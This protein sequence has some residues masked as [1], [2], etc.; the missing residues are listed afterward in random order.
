MQRILLTLALLLLPAS[1]LAQTGTLIQ[2]GNLSFF[3]DSSGRIGTLIDP[4][5]GS[6]KFYSDSTGTFGTII[7]GSGG[8]HF[9]SFTSPIQPLP[10]PLPPVMAPRSSPDA[11]M[12]APSSPSPSPTP[13]QWMPYRRG[14]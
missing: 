5:P 10:D 7:P 11:F 3:S 1:L 12:P 9:Y 14:E 8:T 4:G 6:V 2:S 13:W